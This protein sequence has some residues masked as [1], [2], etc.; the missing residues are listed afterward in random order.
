MDKEDKIKELAEENTRLKEELQE[1]KEHLKKY[2]SP[3][4]NK[5]Y[6]E[7]NKDKHKQMVKEYKEKTNY[8]TNLSSEK[9]KEYAR[10]A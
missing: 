2:T 8:F 6:Y 4:Q 3:I 10:Q 5:I 7:K 9:K 1:T